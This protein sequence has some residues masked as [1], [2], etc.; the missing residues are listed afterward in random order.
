MTQFSPAIFSV[1]F[2]SA[3]Q[4]S[5]SCLYVLAIPFP[6]SSCFFKFPTKYLSLFFMR[7]REREKDVGL[8]HEIGRDLAVFI[9]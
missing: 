8:V 7:S 9:L 5:P 1:D 2:K 3:A 6:R 4:V